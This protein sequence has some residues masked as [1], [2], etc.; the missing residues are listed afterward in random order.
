MVSESA[1]S[2][3]PFL[4]PA[5]VAAQHH[6]LAGVEPESLAQFRRQREGHRDRVLGR[7]RAARDRER[8]EFQHERVA[9]CT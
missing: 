2:G 1:P 7:C 6:V 3:L 4:A 5:D 9:R 8:V